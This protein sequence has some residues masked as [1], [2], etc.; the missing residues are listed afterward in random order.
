M[1]PGAVGACTSHTA[2]SAQ[3]RIRTGPTDH[4]DHP[5]VSNCLARRSI[6]QYAAQR[7]LDEGSAAGRRATRLDFMRDRLRP[8]AMPFSSTGAT[9]NGIRRFRRTHRSCSLVLSNCLSFPRDRDAAG[10]AVVSSRG[11]YDAS[12]LLARGDP[13]FS[14]PSRNYPSV[15]VWP[16]AIIPI[17]SI[18]ADR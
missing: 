10:A 4:L 1:I 7:H 16:I 6:H 12:S 11:V 5:T 9:E 3:G 18:S 14:K 13:G 2:R 15:S 8:S 17:R